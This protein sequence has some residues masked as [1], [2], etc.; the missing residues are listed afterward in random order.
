MDPLG[1]WR[2]T[3]PCRKSFCKISAFY[4]NESG[5]PAD[6]IA[7]LSGSCARF[8]GACARARR[9]VNFDMESAQNTTLELSKMLFIA[10]LRLP[11]A[12]IV[13]QGVSA[14][15]AQRDLSDLLDQSRAWDVALYCPL[16]AMRIGIT[17]KSKRRKWLALSSL[18]CK[19]ESDAELRNL[20]AHPF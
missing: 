7:H 10:E 20:R 6:A 2:G 15:R 12:G 16:I 4:P 13:I 5:G 17:R 18:F 19:P 8:C 14:R 11:H 3:F 9:F 1:V